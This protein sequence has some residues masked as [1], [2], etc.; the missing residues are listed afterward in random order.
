MLQYDLNKRYF[1]LG[2]KMKT[3]KSEQEWIDSYEAAVKKENG[4]QLPVNPGDSQNKLREGAISDEEWVKKYEAAVR[5]ENGGQLN[6][7]QFSP[8]SELTEKAVRVES[9]NSSTPKP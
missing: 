9:E 2:G 6:M 8:S 5:K 4:G 1:R 3:F 7:S